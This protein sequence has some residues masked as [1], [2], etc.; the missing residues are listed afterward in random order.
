MPEIPA[1]YTDISGIFNIQRNLIGNLAPL[2]GTATVDSTIKNIS[3]NLNTLYTNFA[4][5]TSDGLLTHQKDMINFVDNEKARLAQKK[6][7]IDNAYVGKQ[8]AVQLNESYRLKYHQFMKIMFVIIVTLI[9]FI[10]ITFLSTRFP[11]VPSFVFEILSIIIISIGIFAVYFMTINML[12][13]NNAHYD[14]LDIQAPA[15]AGGNVV[16]SAPPAPNLQDLLSGLNINQCIGSSCCAEGTHWDAGNVSC[17]GNSRAA[18]TTIQVAQ[19]SGDF[20]GRPLVK[21]NSP[22]EDVEYTKI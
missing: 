7:D 21:A 6:A 9:L 13:R 10:L 14:Q 19:T 3:N 18:F 11:I 17:V 5:S 8:R 16:I 20:L 15:G 12:R 22:N 4:G 2:S 1:Y